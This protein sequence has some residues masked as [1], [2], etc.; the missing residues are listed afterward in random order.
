M[1]TTGRQFL[2][3]V[4]ALIFRTGFRIPIGSWFRNFDHIASIGFTLDLLLF[5]E[6]N[7]N[8]KEEVIHSIRLTCSRLINF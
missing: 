1:K 5:V 8:R 2:M 3:S 6:L 7:Q 4:I